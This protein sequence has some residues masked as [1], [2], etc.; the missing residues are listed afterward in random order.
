MLNPS[1]LHA[2]NEDSDQTGLM[3]RLIRVFAGRKSFW[4]FCHEAAQ[5]HSVRYLSS[6][7]SL[8]IRECI[9][10]FIYPNLKKLISYE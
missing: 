9:L 8:N 6:A 7:V 4:W 10:L 5:I 2:D 3:P 1:F